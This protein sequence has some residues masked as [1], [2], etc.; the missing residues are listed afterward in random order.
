[1]SSLRNNPRPPSLYSPTPTFSLRR[2]YFLASAG[3]DAY[4]LSQHVNQTNIASAFEPLEPLQDTDV[5]GHLQHEQQQIILSAIDQGRRETLE[6]FNKSLARTLHSRWGRQK[7]RIFEEL[8]QH[9][10]SFDEGAG[11]S[12]STRNRPIAGR[13]S[14]SRFG[15]IPPA[16][17]V[18]DPPLSSLSMHTKLM[19]YD[20]LIRALN[21]A[22]L[23]STPY[24][25]ASE[26]LRH[27][28]NS[29]TSGGAPGETQTQLIECWLAV[30][31]IIG[32]EPPSN[33]PREREFSPAYFDASTYYDRPEGVELR[34]R[35]VK[36]SKAFL[37]TQFETHI[38]NVIASNPAK[39]QLGGQP[40]MVSRV[41]AF[42]RVNLLSREGR[43]SSE[44]ELLRQQPNA[45]PL[46]V[47][48]TIFHLLRTGHPIDALRQAEEYEEAMRRS[49]G[50]FVGWIKEWIESGGRGLSRAARDRFFAEYNA[51]FRN[52]AIGGGG[53][54][55]DA[56]GVD[57][58]KLA[59]YRLIGRVDPTRKFPNALTRSTEN[60]LWLQ[61]MMTREP[62][63]LASSAFDDGDEDQREKYTVEDLARKLRTYGEKHF[64]PKGRRPLHYFLVLLL[65]GEFERAVAFL[66]SRPHHQADAVHFAI[67]LAYYGLL[68]CPSPHD[69]KAAIGGEILSQAVSAG[70]RQVAS[71]DLARVI[72]RHIRLFSM[73]DARSA[74]EYIYLI[75]LNVEPSVPSDTQEDQREKCYGAIKD[76]VCQTRMYA[77]LVGDIRVDGARVPGAIEQSLKLLRMSDEREYLRQIVRAA[78]TRSEVEHR[79]RD[80]ILLFNLAEEYDMVVSV[81]NREL[82]ASLFLT[83]LSSGLA[84]LDGAGGSTALNASASLTATEDSAQLAKAILDNYEAQS[85][86]ARRVDVKKR[87]TCRL[88]LELKRAVTLVRNGDIER[89]L[90]VIENTNLFPLSASSASSSSSTGSGGGDVVSISRRAESFFR[91]V[92]ESVGRNLSELLLMTM[93]LLYKVHSNLKSGAANTGPTAAAAAPVEG[94]EARLQEIRN[95]AR[96]LMMFAAM[97]RFR[98]EQSVFAQITRLD[99]FIR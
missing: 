43:W 31:S 49:D 96:A 86:I 9:Q 56:H 59:L 78:A 3:I 94:I 69:S 98:I 5:Q 73:S 65:S 42:L 2:H 72:T 50:A 76:L 34:N 95:K 19:S 57:P 81:L 80:A 4:T 97:L 12:A 64:D 90:N 60:W 87:E 40:G 26:F 55:A 38:D 88:L 85:H 13:A 75:C 15:S 71:I 67:T 52:L 93:D 41:A 22:R 63:S 66:Y 35:I 77:D 79:T 27:A 17:A 29:A 21:Q 58:Y 30:K 39:A 32:E 33:I 45:T 46:P 10:S 7:K 37:E 36:G 25:L 47:W 18:S 11:L 91:D 8:G 92:D 23:K 44:L 51:R 1:M 61:L 54:A 14:I 68:R 70:N 53:G 48:A 74:L 89:G 24:P 62:S 84:L 82:G 20:N 99:A 28:Q 6:D 16:S 83:D